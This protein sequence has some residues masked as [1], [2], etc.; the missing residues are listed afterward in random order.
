MD[1][2]YELNG[3]TFVWDASKARVNLT[4]HQVASEQAA[5]V[6]FD[7]FFKVIDASPD[8]EARDA[9]IGMDT[10]WNLLSVVHIVIED[11]RIRII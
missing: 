1:E 7:P 2:R 9:I 6:F 5:E 4:K 3:I 8:T 10:A 11:E